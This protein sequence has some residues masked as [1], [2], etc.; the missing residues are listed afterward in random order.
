MKNKGQRKN[1][2]F[3]GV[4]VSKNTLD[5]AIMNNQ[6]LLGH[7]QIQNE[8]T[9]I[10]RFVRELK[11]LKNFTFQKCV[12]GLEFT[13]IYGN[14]ILGY[15]TE[16]KA[17][18][19]QQ[20]AIHIKNSLGTLR[21]K[22][23]KLD[24]IRIAKYLSKEG[25]ALCLWEPKRKIIQQLASLSTLRSRLLTTSLLI[26][27]PLREDSGFVI[28]EISEL[29]KSICSET[30]SALKSALSKVESQIKTVFESDSRL[31]QLMQL[32]TSVPC[33]GPVTALQIIISTNEFKDIN[34]PKKF[35][36]YAGIAPFP[37]T[38]GTSLNRRSRVSKMAN[39]KMKALIHVCALSA[40]RYTPEIITYYKRKT[41]IEGKH[42]MLVLNAIRFKLINRVFACVNNNTPYDSD[43]VRS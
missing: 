32:I 38:S 35:A 2:F 40:K 16:L 42:K 30:I 15:L 10:Q 27:T 11:E 20:S 21:G 5:I 17:N 22:T 1:S 3:V 7:T 19:V 9:E 25:D 26:K 18:I 4:D 28:R 6:T 14:H 34:S 13:G 37:H 33:I 36:C 12:F 23:D 8:P 31:N 43:Y 24:A 29:N 41:E 39:K